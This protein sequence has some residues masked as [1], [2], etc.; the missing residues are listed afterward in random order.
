MTSQTFDER[1]MRLISFSYLKLPET[2]TMA[3]VRVLHEVT[4]IY[5]VNV[6]I[7]RQTSLT[8]YYLAFER[9]SHVACA[10]DH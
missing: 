8:S 3:N 5:D 4:I 1:S 2:I 6:Q 9:G 7:R 10:D